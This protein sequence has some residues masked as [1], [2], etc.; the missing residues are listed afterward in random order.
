MCIVKVDDVNLELFVCVRLYDVNVR[1]S[2]KKHRTIPNDRNNI[3]HYHHLD[4]IWTPEMFFFFFLCSLVDAKLSDMNS[5]WGRERWEKK[6]INKKTVPLATTIIKFFYSFLSSSLWLSSE[7]MTLSILFSFCYSDDDD[8]DVV[9]IAWSIIKMLNNWPK[10]KQRETI[11][12]GWW[13]WIRLNDFFTQTP[14][15]WRDLN[16]SL[17]FE[18]FISS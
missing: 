5:D 15:R 18:K 9:W 17:M 3:N 12:R 11:K 14:K 2:G 10:K 4:W 1:N 6:G 13:F 16:T 7:K 8:D